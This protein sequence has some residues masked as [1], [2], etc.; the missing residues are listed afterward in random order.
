MFQSVLQKDNK[1]CIHFDFDLDTVYKD[2]AHYWPFDYTTGIRDHVTSSDATFFGRDGIRLTGT[3]NGHLALDLWRS[4]IRLGEYRT[5]CIIALSNCTS[6]VS[7]AF[8]IKM[9]GLGRFAALK[10]GSQI[11]L[12]TVTSDRNFHNIECK[13]IEKQGIFIAFFNEFSRQII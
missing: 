6:G 10:D 12:L 1:L 7:L 3:G 9:N 13:A 2:T 4:A 8:W 11:N 5:Q